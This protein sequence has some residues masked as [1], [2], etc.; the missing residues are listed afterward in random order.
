MGLGMSKSLNRA[1]AIKCKFTYEAREK[2]FCQLMRMP[3]K[4]TETV[5]IVSEGTVSSV[6]ECPVLKVFETPGRYPSAE[7]MMALY[8][9]TMVKKVTM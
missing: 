9:F 3:S 7:G 5:C 1:N 8:Q 2:I 4:E 6:K